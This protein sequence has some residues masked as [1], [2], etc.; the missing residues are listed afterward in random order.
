MFGDGNYISM[1]DIS[2]LSRN[3]N[4]QYWRAKIV[5]LENFLNSLQPEDPSFEILF[6]NPQNKSVAQY[7]DVLCGSLPGVNDG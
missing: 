7:A 2:R 5:Y 1:L 6:T 4:S 3:Y